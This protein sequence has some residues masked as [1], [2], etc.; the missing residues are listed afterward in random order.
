MKVVFRNIFQNKGHRSSRV[1][2]TNPGRPIA[3]YPGVTRGG[4]CPLDGTRI[5]SEHGRML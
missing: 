5:Y 2:I 1:Q 4:L 3:S